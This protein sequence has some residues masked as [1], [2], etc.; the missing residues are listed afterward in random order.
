MGELLPA[1]YEGFIQALKIR[2]AEE[3]VR[4]AL[5]ANRA[6]VLLYGDIGGPSWPARCPTQLRGSLPTVEEL[7]RELAG[8]EE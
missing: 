3:R 2:S 1:G 5:S 7:E 6:Q 4:V 8:G